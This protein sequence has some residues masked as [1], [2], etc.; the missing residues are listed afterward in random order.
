MASVREELRRIYTSQ[1]GELTPQAVVDAARRKNSPLNSYFEWDDRV[2]GEAYRIVQA[3]DLIRRQ[4]KVYAR[5]KRGPKH[6][7]EYVSVY[8]AGG[9]D[10]GAYRLTE[11]VVVDPISEAI[12][13]R[14][15]QRDIDNLK[16]RYGHFKEF[17][18]LVREALGEEDSA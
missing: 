1:G 6:V 16:R 17:G 10:T 15:F 5:D 18:R 3:Q 4:F 13:L 7:R 2:A 14:E 8:Q 9:S 12:L 11:E